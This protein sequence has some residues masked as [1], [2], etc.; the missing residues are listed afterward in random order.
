MCR[1]YIG[2]YL[3]AFRRRDGHVIP[4]MM[5]LRHI[6]IYGVVL[7]G[8]TAQTYANTHTHEHK[9][10]NLIWLTRAIG[11]AFFFSRQKGDCEQVHSWFFRV[12]CFL[13]QTHERVAC[14]LKRAHKKP[15]VIHGATSRRRSRIKRFHV[16]RQ[17]LEK[18]IVSHLCL[19]KIRRKERVLSFAAFKEH[20][21][22]WSS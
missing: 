14:T 6:Y 12:C 7:K 20:R 13:Q 3:S 21:Y 8:P 19:F 1:K 11:F 5:P 9:P 2:L 16:A 4:Q 22:L 10:S 17:Q 15:F 18:I